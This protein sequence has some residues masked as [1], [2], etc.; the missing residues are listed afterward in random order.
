MGDYRSAL[1]TEFPSGYAVGLLMSA[2]VAA[3]S[4]IFIR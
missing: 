2:L 4:F 1:R 3:K